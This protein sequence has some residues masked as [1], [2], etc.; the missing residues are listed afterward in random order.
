MVIV[1]SDGRASALPHSLCMEGNKVSQPLSVEEVKK[2]VQARTQEETLHDAQMTTER[3]CHLKP[4]SLAAETLIDVLGNQEGRYTLGIPELDL[5]TRGFDRGELAI[6][7]AR[8][9]MGK[10]Q[11]V[12]NAVVNNPNKN[13]ILF[14]P[15]EVA[16]L[17]LTKLY[18]IKYGVNAEEI[19]KK[20]ENG[21]ETTIANIRRA[22]A[23]EFKNLVVIDDTLDFKQMTDA[24]NEAQDFWGAQA[25]IAIVDY[26][27]LIPGGGEGHESVVA[28]AQG[29]KR[30]T[31]NARVPTIC[32]HQASRSS[33]ARGQ[34]AG[35]NALRY[36]GGEAEAIYVIEVFR[37]REDE[38]MDDFD[39]RRHQ[40]TI[41]VNLVKNKKPPSKVG[42]ADLYIDPECGRIRTL[43]PDDMLA[44]GLPVDNIEQAR[45][46]AG[47]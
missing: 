37:K 14:T 25:D 17:V 31:K 8:P 29:L 41:T 3:Y 24:L 42:M 33:G 5:M 9:H 40:N 7:T 27:E 12:L 47:R 19:E 21:D 28:K 34:A 18:S 30:W 1:N 44:H 38:S 15:D 36:G 32:L 45:K 4:L 10:T 11:L 2:L 6:I 13:T 39:R 26:L 20:V 22:A 46:L 43:Q 16:P 23:H 35:L